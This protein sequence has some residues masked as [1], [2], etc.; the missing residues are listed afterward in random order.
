MGSADAVVERLPKLVRDAGLLHLGQVSCGA[1]D[2]K[3]RKMVPNKTIRFKVGLLIE[4]VGRATA[5]HVQVEVD[6]VEGKP[7]HKILHLVIGDVIE[8]V[9][10]VDVLLGKAIVKSEEV[11][12]PITLRATVGSWPMTEHMS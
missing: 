4:V 7:L 2:L 12:A 6:V 3:A 5:G 9:V 10:L 11:L 8:A 1:S